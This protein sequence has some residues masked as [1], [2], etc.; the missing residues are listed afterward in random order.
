MLPGPFV[1]V[2]VTGSNRSSVEHTLYGVTVAI[3]NELSGMQ[4]GMSRNNRI[5]VSTISYAPQATLSMS[6]TGRSL[7][8]DRRAV[9]HLCTVRSVIVDAQI[10]RRRLRRTADLMSRPYSVASESSEP[11]RQSDMRARNRMS[12]IVGRRPGSRNSGHDDHS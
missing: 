6:M 11:E 5:S 2:T 1:A 10:T 7:R 8:P 4:S 9:G 12:R 3:G